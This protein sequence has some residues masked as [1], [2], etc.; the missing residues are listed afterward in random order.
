M[1]TLCGVKQLQL[2]TLHFHVVTHVNSHIYIQVPSIN[3]YTISNK[4]KEH[5]EF[6]RQY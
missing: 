1:M 6:L 5:Q 4:Y 2:G 3:N